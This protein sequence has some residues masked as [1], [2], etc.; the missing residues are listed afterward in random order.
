MNY[1]QKCQKLLTDIDKYTNDDLVI[2]FSGGID[3]SLLLRLAT[4]S[5]KEKGNTV[6]AVTIHTK[7]HPMNDL[8]VAKAVASEMGAVHKVIHVDELT[9][10]NIDNNPVDR[11]YRC[12]KHLFS[13]LKALVTEYGAK[14]LIDGTNFDDLSQYRPG[15]KALKELEVIS[16]LCD[17]EFTKAEVRQFAESYNISVAQ[18]PSAPCLA[19][20]FPYDTKISYEIMHNIDIAEEY[21]RSLG[22][23]N[24][25][26]RVHGDIARVEI[27]KV[28]FDKF[29]KYSEDIVS[30]LKELGFIY[31]TLDIEGFR[32]GSMDINLV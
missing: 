30:K 11:C 29:L 24:V 6:Y 4:L 5:A 18:R 31:I 3:S 16:P 15:L 8:D 9:E 19:T 27:D 7:L 21:I 1:N 14:N 23:Y 2:A 28:D 17:S 25:R 10:A 20:R 26:L 22:F 12:K 32:S 13:E